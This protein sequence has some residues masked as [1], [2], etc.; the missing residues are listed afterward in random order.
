MCRAEEFLSGEEMMAMANAV[1]NSKF[2]GQRVLDRLDLVEEGVVGII[3]AGERYDESK[4]KFST[5]A[6]KSAYRKML[7][8]VMRES[9]KVA[10]T[11]YDYDFDC[12][13]EEDDDYDERKIVSV[14]IVGKLRELNKNDNE[15]LNELLACKKQNDVAKE[16]NVST[17]RV[18][19]VFRDFK[20]SVN[21]RFEIINGE[22]C[23]K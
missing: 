7:R 14:G 12:I 2:R 9:G 18:S 17:Q 19:K 15:I 11:V 20:N 4:G 6:W 16:F 23:E 1:Y 21:E 22:L 8:A 13:G 5:Y 3:R 10:N